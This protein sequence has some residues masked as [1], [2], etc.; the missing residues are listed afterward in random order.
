MSRVT[1]FL[2]FNDQLEAALEFHDK[3][4]KKVRAVVEAMMEMV[5]L[6]VATLERAF[7]EG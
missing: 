1:P 4:P 2:M 7:A 6:D 5:K 3:N